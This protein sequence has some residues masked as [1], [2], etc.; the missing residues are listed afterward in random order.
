MHKKLRPYMP[1]FIVAGIAA[2]APVAMF[3]ASVLYFLLHKLSP[4]RASFWSWVDYF[5]KDP[6]DR[7]TQW[8]AMGIALFATYV[9]IP[10]FIATLRYKKPA[11]HGDARFATAHEIRQAELMGDEGIIVGQYEGR[12]LRFAGQRFVILAAPTRSGKGV[13]IVIPNC[14]TYTQSLVVTDIKL[15]NFKKT[16]GY[17]KTVMG[18]EVF[19]FNPFAGEPAD[20]DDPDS[21]PTPPCTHCWNPLD[22]VPR[23]NFR[24]GEIMSIGRVFWPGI[25]PK[26]KFWDE[27]ALNV[28]TGVVM[29]LCELRDKRREEIAETGK[30]PIPDYPVSFGEVLRQANGRGSGKSAKAFLKMQLE[31][32]PWL[33][34]RCRDALSKFVASTDEVAQS[35][36]DTLTNPLSIWL[37]PIVDAAT[38]RSDFKLTAVRK[39][40]MT[41]YVGIPPKRLVDAARLI[42]LFFSQLVS[43]NTGELPEDNPKLKYACLLLM[44]EFT[45]FGKIEI[46]S[47]AVSHIAG[48]NLRLMPIIQSISQLETTYGKGEAE[49]FVTNHAMQIVYAPRDQGDANKVSEALG[50][51]T[52]KNDSRSRST[53][54]RGSSSVSTSDQRRALMMPQEVKK[55]G[56]WKEIIFLENLD[57]IFCD[58]IKYFEDPFFTSRLLPPPVLEELDVEQFLARQENRLRDITNADIDFSE[59]RLVDPPGASQL[60]LVGECAPI[61]TD[62]GDPIDEKAMFDAVGTMYTAAGVPAESIAKI[63]DQISADA[64]ARAAALESF[65]NGPRTGDIETAGIAGTHGCTLSGADMANVFGDLGDDELELVGA[66]TDPL[67]EDTIVPMQTDEIDSA[68]GVSTQELEILAPDEGSTPTTQTDDNPFGALASAFGTDEEEHDPMEVM[69]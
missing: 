9:L 39:K 14:L 7:I 1:V 65:E 62:Y 40:L 61:P 27:G 18:Q 49:N 53:G 13:G 16:A 42:N 51:F 17:R 58:K 60:Q 26:Q 20:P 38:S 66:D 19:L 67:P 5:V 54:G 43:L 69:Q 31:A 32:Y 28:F 50:Y 47:K 24:I 52:L 23:G 25:D 44:D 15:E 59:L 34:P 6:S 64:H 41:I 48:Y 68:F 4:L 21:E 33:S 35:T 63:A 36:I 12:I 3:L 56:Q 37:N 29:M 55:M 45:A 22:A 30:T 57:P 46:I 11:L 8:K 2:L 10:L